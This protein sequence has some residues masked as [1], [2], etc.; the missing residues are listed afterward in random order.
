MAQSEIM[1]LRRRA[2]RLA[3]H[4]DYGQ[5]RIGE[6]NPRYPEFARVWTTVGRGHVVTAE[7]WGAVDGVSPLV[8]ALDDLVVQLESRRTARRPKPVEETG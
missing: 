5:I 6:I 8:R 1:R 3:G 2:A 4:N 7:A